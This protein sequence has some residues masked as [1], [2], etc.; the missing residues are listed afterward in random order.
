VVVA[1]ACKGSV[2]RVI[3]VRRHGREKVK[4]AAQ[5]EP[6][7]VSARATQRMLP[8]SLKRVRALR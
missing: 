1:G 7:A 4:Q 2:W 8:F 3:P 5:V 6:C